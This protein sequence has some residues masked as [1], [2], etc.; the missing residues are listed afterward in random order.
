MN[1]GEVAAECLR[2]PCQFPHEVPEL[3]QKFRV[4]KFGVLI[5]FHVGDT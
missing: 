1:L 3:G 4:G 5:A 2:R